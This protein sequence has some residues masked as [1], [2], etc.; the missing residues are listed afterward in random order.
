MTQEEKDKYYAII[1]YNTGKYTMR[2]TV[3]KTD[4]LLEG[5]EALQYIEESIKFDIEY[6]RKKIAA[7]EVSEVPTD[8][9]SE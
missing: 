7:D 5:E 4:I 6:L 9:D 2:S 1:E 8:L 3:S